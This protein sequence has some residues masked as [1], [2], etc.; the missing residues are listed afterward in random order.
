L[1]HFKGTSIFAEKFAKNTQMSSCMK[2][3]PLEAELFHADRRAW[4]S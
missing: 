1:S 4:R 2:I 3:C